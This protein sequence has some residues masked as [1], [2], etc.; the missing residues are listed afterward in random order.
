MKTA[1][2]QTSTARRTIVL[3]STSLVI[4]WVSA[5]DWGADLPE[6]PL[7]TTV[8]V[9][10]AA[11][12]VTALRA[13]LQMTADVRDQHGQ[14]MPDAAVGWNTRVPDVAQIDT[15]GVVTAVSNGIDTVTATAGTAVGT[16]VVTVVQTA[17]EVRVAPAA[18]TLPRGFR[19]QMTAEARDANGHPLPEAEFEWTSTDTLVAVVDESGEVEGVAQGLATIVATLG[20]L[21][22]SSEITVVDNPDRIALTALYNSTG[23][24]YWTRA[25]N[26]LD[27]GELQ[28]WY[29]VTTNSNG[30]VIGLNL[31]DNG[32]A[33]VI[34]PESGN[35]TELRT[36]LLASN[37]LVGPIPAEIGNLTSLETVDL[38]FNNLV[39]SIPPEWGDLVNLR[40]LLLNHNSLTGS[41]PAEL[42][43]LASLLQLRLRNNYLTGPIPPQLGNLANLHQ[44][45]LSN[46]S[47]TGSIPSDLAKLESVVQINVSGNELTGPIPAELAGLANLADLYLADNNLEGTI[48]A[49]LMSLP[50]L[51]FLGLNDNELGGPLPSGAYRLRGLRAMSLQGNNF[52]GPIPRSLGLL[53]SLERLRLSDNQLTGPIPPELGNLGRLLELELSH[54]QLTSIPPGLGNLGRLLELELADNRFTSIPPELGNLGRLLRLNLMSNPGLSGPLPHSFTSLGELAQLHTGDT[55]LCAPADAAFRSWLDRVLIHRTPVCGAA[56]ARTYLTQSTQSREFPVSLVSGEDA[57][58]RVFVVATQSSDETIPDVRATF[59]RAGGQTHTVDIAGKSE[60]IPTSVD[61]SSLST[62]ANAV[63]PGD[64]IQ[65]GLEMV[66]EIDPHGTLDPELGVPTRIPETGRIEV[67]VRRMTVLDLTII[68]LLW[69]QDPDSSILELTEAMAADPE[70]HEMLDDVRTL[71]PVR[72]IEALRHSPMWIGIN[73]AFWMLLRTEA[74]R[75]MEGGTG[76]YMGMM[77]GEVRG[78]RG[79]AFLPGR[80]SFSTPHAWII[81]HELGHNMHLAH[82]P[83]GGARRPDPLYPYPAGAIGTWGYD[84]RGE[85]LVPPQVADLL[86]YCAPRWISEY[87]FS[88]A[89]RYRLVDEGELGGSA[90]RAPRKSL[91]LWGGTDDDGVPFLEPAFVVEAPPTLPRTDGD[92]RLTGNTATGEE[93]FS[94][95][96]RMPTVADGGGPSSFVFALPV[97]PEWGGKLAGITLSGP[98][99]SVVLDG[100]SDDPMAILRDL[101][102]GQVRAILTDLPSGVNDWA[103]AAAALRPEPDLKLLFS[104]GIP[105]STAWRR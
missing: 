78:A 73:E 16:A 87:H 6:P 71:L 70:G 34:P 35:L 17:R 66:I 99:G 29:G 32:L 68:P 36:L 27:E 102:T 95:R 25:T 41:I 33:G 88:R 85:T 61:E 26:W 52:T 3:A 18:D 5:C 55:D 69:A 81:A 12:Q 67:A 40:L 62:S 20:G 4:A 86:S 45:L 8:T 82:A 93:L 38:G 21:E 24:S 9:T 83:C 59:Y 47:L 74:V 11:A 10:P 97:E 76:H 98:G 42:G 53:S 94:L 63:I 89:L 50:S 90:A 72:E 103:G 13:T 60:V 100:E 96:F 2:R 19:L 105:D 56:E 104:R 14:A 1:V 51:R 23:G 75:V 64:V 80:S 49:E 31:H 39:G 101:R 22:G 57:L 92:H 28:N 37:S 58:L 46:N 91:L 54:N 44:L 7:P 43:K 65:P 48:P 79:I 77:A 30:R 15:A 84:P